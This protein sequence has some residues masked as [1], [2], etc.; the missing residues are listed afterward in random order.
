MRTWFTADTH[1]GHARIIEYCGRPFGSVGEMDEALVA[2]WNAV[3]Q[4]GDEVWHLGDF[5]LG[6]AETATRYLHRLRGRVHL[7][8]GN[9]DKAEVRTL[10]E[11][12]SSRAFAEV[13]VESTRV[14]LFHYGMRVWPRQHR[15]ALHFYG[16]SHGNL[17]ELPGSCDVG[18]DN[19]AWNYRPVPL[20]EIKRHLARAPAIAGETTP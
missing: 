6:N 11:W 3:V 16:H 4:D 15:G 13:T 9:H 7:V 5:A 12:A 1:F 8:W 20:R 17:P 10:P 2:N 19:P 18:I 14:V